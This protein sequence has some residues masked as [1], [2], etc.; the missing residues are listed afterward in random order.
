MFTG[1]PWERSSQLRPQ[2]DVGR[3]ETAWGMDFYP[4]WEFPETLVLTAVLP[5]AAKAVDGYV[6]PQ[7]K[8]VVPE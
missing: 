8:Q 1:G 3:R 2:G 7:I 5:L 6:K 4:T